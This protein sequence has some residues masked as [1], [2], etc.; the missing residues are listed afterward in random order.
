MPFDLL[1]GVLGFG[2]VLGE[3]RQFIGFIGPGMSR[4]RRFQQTLGDQIGVAAVRGSGVSIILDRQAEVPG[5]AGSR[6]FDDVFPGAQE[7]DNAEGK[8]GKAKRIGGFYPDQELFQGFWVGLL[9]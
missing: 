1:G 5:R 7:L 2:A 3:R 6:K 8:I 4:Q 9:G